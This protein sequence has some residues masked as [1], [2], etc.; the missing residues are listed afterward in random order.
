[1]NPQ[2]LEIVA[3]F[4]D[5]DKETGPQLLRETRLA[6]AVRYVERFRRFKVEIASFI[7]PEQTRQHNDR[8]F[9][10]FPKLTTELRLKIWQ[11]ADS[12]RQRIIHVFLQGAQDAIDWDWAEAMSPEPNSSYGIFVAEYQLLSK[13]LRVSRVSRYET[14]RFHRIH[15]PCRLTSKP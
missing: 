4:I 3:G 5:N 9:H 15:V 6:K 7:N 11:L 1:M 13:F 2:A 8:V 12:R 10:L 14:L